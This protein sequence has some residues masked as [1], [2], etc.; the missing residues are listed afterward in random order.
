MAAQMVVHDGVALIFEIPH[1]GLV[2][3][4]KIKRAAAIMMK[5]TSGLPALF[6]NFLYIT[7]QINPSI[8]TD[9]SEALPSPIDLIIEPENSAGLSITAEL[10][11]TNNIK[12]AIRTI[13]RSLKK[14]EIVAQAK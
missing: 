5:I 12:K 10:N 6:E 3:N 13:S 11:E 9:E 4:P 2:E 1:K 7:P 8:V 14:S